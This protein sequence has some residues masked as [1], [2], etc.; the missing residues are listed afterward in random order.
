[1]SAGRCLPAVSIAWS[2][3]L[4]TATSNPSLFKTSSKP[5][6]M[7]GLS[8]TTSIFVLRLSAFGLVSDFVIRIS[9]LGLGQAAAAEESNY[10]TLPE[11]DKPRRRRERG[12]F[13]AP[14]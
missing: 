9:D 13:A 10:L 12:R 5:S 7:C 14:G 3:R 1:M 2:P 4:H 6:R 8:S 11:A